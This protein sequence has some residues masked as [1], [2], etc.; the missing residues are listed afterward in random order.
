MALETVARVVRAEGLD[1][2]GRVVG[3]T[4]TVRA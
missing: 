1:A 3:R 4:R 2:D